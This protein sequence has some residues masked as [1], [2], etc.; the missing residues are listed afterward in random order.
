[1][2]DCAHDIRIN[3]DASQVWADLRTKM[4]SVSGNNINF[5][6]HEYNKHGHCCTMK[7]KFTDG[8]KS[9]FTKVIEIYSRKQYANIYK[10]IAKK[11]DNR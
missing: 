5:W 6:K 1:M 11:A 10:S 3:P 7:Y 4:I 8:P 2:P 9:Y